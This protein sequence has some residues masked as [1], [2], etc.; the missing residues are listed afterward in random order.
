MARHSQSAHNLR[1]T[2]ALSLLLLL[3]LL[4]VTLGC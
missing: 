4:V 1:N 3:L 2:R